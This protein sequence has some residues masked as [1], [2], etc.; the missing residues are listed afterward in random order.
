[1]IPPFKWLY[2]FLNTPAEWHS[3]VIGFS[4]VICPWRPPLTIPKKELEYLKGEWHYYMFG[5]AVG[6]FAWLGIIIFF[7]K[8]IYGI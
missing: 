2:T 6:V 1:M 5:R 8:V 7:W 3:W 4:Q